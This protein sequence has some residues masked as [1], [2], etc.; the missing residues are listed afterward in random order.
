MANAFRF[1]AFFASLSGA[2]AAPVKLIIDTDIGGGGCRD[3]DDVAAVAIGNALADAGKAELLAVVVNT[4]PVKCPGVASVLNHYY[5]R[6]DVPIGQYKGS[7][8]K[9]SSPHAYVDDLVDHWD[10]PIKDSSQVPSSTEVYRKV[11]SVQRDH[12]VSISSIGLTTNLRAL[13][14]SQ[15]DE[16]S[17][18]SGIELVAQKVKALYVMGGM[19]SGGGGVSCNLSGGVGSD[20]AAGTASSVYAFTHWPASVQIVFSGFEVG[21]K[22][23]TGGPIYDCV[24]ESNPARQAFI[25]FVG[26]GNTRPSWDPLTTMASVLGPEA[27]GTSF[28]SDCDGT[29]SVDPVLGSNAW[30]RGPPSNQTYLVLNNASFAEAAM[31]ELLCQPPTNPQPAHAPSSAVIV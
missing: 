18:L 9:V 7:D 24:P 21:V 11:L 30:V 4:S 10:S 8:L 2:G 26:Y 28:C 12:S 3:V 22:V 1:S 25:D 14:E 15:G 19:F 6:D 16:H 29:I 13:L 27:V 5:G 23:H 17:P 31:N 20:H